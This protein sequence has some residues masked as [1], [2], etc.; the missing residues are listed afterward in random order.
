MQKVAWITGGGRGIGAAI[1]T[2]LSADGFAVAVSDINGESARA[3]ADELNA[4]GAHAIGM[5]GD[6]TKQDSVDANIAAVLAR[7]GRVDVAV[8]NA[9]I[10]I[11]GRIDEL[12]E[13]DFERTLAVNTVGVWR[14]NRAVITPMRSQ[15]A[16][17]IINAASIAG[18][19]GSTLNSIYVA[20][21]FAV[22]GLTQSFAHELAPDGITVNAYCPGIVDT[23]MWVLLDARKAE[24]T[25]VESGVSLQEAVDT[26]VLGRVETADDVAGFVSFLASPDSDYMTGQSVNICGGIHML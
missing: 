1:A 9:G 10:V 20:S 19:R 13:A 12:T 3:L 25:G 18:H 5:D 17:K 14:T 11:P 22:V 8:A 7:F 6:V 23:D 24:M 16:G 21:K 4:Q 15:G 26:T 2:R